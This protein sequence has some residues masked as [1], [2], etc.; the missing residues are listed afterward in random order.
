MPTHPL[1]PYV[2]SPDGLGHDILSHSSASMPGTGSSMTPHASVVEKLG[3]LAESSLS[4]DCMFC[5]ET[6]LH[7]EDLGPHLL[8]QHPTTFHAPAVLR[9]GKR[10]S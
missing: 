3:T 10:N 9:V 6:F 8:S 7:Q 5:E 2:E 4:L 1:I